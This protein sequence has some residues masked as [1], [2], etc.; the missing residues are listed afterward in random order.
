MITPQQTA[1]TPEQVK[2]ELL[3]KGQTISGWAREHNFTP[4]EVTLVINGFTKGRYGK[5]HEIAVALGIKA[6]QDQQTA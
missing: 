4:R 3:A 6:S 5:G 2:A 1:K